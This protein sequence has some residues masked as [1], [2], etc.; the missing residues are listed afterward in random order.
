MRALHYDFTMTLNTSSEPR[1]AGGLLVGMWLVALLS[2]TI[3]DGA[4]FVATTNGFLACWGRDDDG[5][6]TISNYSS[7][8]F[9][10][11]QHDATD[12]HRRHR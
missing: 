9:L 4:P 8:S 10:P 7:S 12:A 1:Y 2:L 6:S 11:S 3:P 5:Q